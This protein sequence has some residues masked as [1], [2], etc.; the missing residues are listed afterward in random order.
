M[1]TYLIDPSQRLSLDTVRS[2][3]EN[4]MHVGLSDI[5]VSRI[6]SCREYL[7][8][9]IETKLDW[10][11]ISRTGNIEFTQEIVDKYI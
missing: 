9:K 10:S 11:R 7:D 6:V 8:K 3:I 2:I 1:K 5:A 4:G